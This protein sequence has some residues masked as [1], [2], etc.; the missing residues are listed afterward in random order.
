MFDC[1]MLNDELDLLELRLH[2]LDPVIEKFVIVESP[3]THSGKDKPLHYL[4]NCQRFKEFWPKIEHLIYPGYSVSTG[5]EAWGNENS[6]RNYFLEVTKNIFP[7]DGL[8]FY[9]DL[10]EIP[11]PEKLLEA[12]DKFV[13][14][15]NIPVAFNLS[16]CLYYMNYAFAVPSRGP[17]LYDPNRAKDFHAKFGVN[18]YSPT[19]IRW[20]SNAKGCE[21]DFQNVNDAGWHFSAL[22][23]IERLKKKISSCAHIEFDT[24]KIN[25]ENHLIKAIEQGRAYFD[26]FEV[27]NAVDQT[28]SK[29]PLDFLPK[30]VLENL[31]K[32]KPYILD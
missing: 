32:F 17:I 5:F 15:S 23:G 1:T 24:E 19:S 25:N 3:K 26:E 12:K 29:Q 11:K 16:Y 30:Y 4:D 22:G 27:F 7:S 31:E 21:N 10:D 8:F 9:S 20:H 14:N 18:H 2:T 28:C 13:S 6:Q